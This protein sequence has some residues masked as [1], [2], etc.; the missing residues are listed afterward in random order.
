[1][2]SDRYEPYEVDV[3]V[4]IHTTEKALK[5]EVGLKNPVWIA[6][7]EILEDEEGDINK[8]AS[9]GESGTLFIPMWLA[10]DSGLV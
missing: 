9:T 4:I 6:R 10:E 3:D 7:S 2:T 5:C 1:M 8:D